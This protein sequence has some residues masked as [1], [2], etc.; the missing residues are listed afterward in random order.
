LIDVTVLTLLVLHIGASTIWLGTSIFSEIVLRP[1]LATQSKMHQAMDL[2]KNSARNSVLLVWISLILLSST[3]LLLLW[4][5]NWLTLSFLTGSIGGGIMLTGMILTLGGIL[6]GLVI[7]AILMPKNSA[8][9]QLSLR[10][11]M[12]FSA[13]IIV[14]MVLFYVATASSTVTL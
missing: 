9:L 11:N 8:R 3:G 6:N 14:L 2:S 13:S 4:L 10:I 5:E 12:I 7:T 1:V